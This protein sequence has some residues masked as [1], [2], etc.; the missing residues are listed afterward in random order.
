MQSIR[1]RTFSSILQRPVS[2]TPSLRLR[3]SSAQTNPAE[4]DLAAQAIL[5]AKA[6]IL[7]PYHKVSFDDRKVRVPWQDG[8]TS[9]LYVPLL[10]C[11]PRTLSKGMLHA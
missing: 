7:S 11:S 6:K 8:K 5:A 3:F 1:L 10:I 2:F 9:A 4:E